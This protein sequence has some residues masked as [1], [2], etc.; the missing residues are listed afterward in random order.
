MPKRVI[1][2]LTAITLLCSFSLTNI[3]A[4]QTLCEKVGIGDLSAHTVIK[5]DGNEGTPEQTN[6]Q[7]TQIINLGSSI[8][9]FSNP[10]N[11]DYRISG[12]SVCSAILNS[13]DLNLTE[14]AT[15][16]G[17]NIEYIRVGVYT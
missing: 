5:L 16:E 1:S 2:I 3:F 12:D 6:I 15:S 11:D 7:N 14:Q 10:W 4:E 9:V 8:G 13:T 17:Y